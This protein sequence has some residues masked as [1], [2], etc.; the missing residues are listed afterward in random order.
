MKQTLL[1]TN[2]DGIHAEGLHVLRK[3][4]EPIWNTIVVAPE[5]E[6]SASSHSLTLNKPLRVRKINDTTM[7]V[8]G[9]PADCVMLSLEGLLD[10]KPDLVV[11]GINSG[12]IL[13]RL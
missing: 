6:Q 8:D 13:I 10:I 4:V 3:T 11:S 2:D 5:S 1:L 12:A 7:A 9:T